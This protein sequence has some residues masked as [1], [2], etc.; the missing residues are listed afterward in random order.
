MG[1]MERCI[2]YYEIWVLAT[3]QVGLVISKQGKLL[4]VVKGSDLT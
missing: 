4:D 1:F 2:V 3:H